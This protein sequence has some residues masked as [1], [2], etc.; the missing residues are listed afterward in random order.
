MWTVQED[1]DYIKCT[2]IC[3]I[4]MSEGEK[5]EK[6]LEK[7]FEEIIAKNLAN[8]GKDSFA[9]IQELQRIPYRSNPRRNTLDT[10]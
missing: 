4:S 1:W 5:R 7:I 2:N 6:E 10:Y 9:Q 8:M 3:I